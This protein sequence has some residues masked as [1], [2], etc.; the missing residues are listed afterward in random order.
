MKQAAIGWIK[1]RDG[2]IVVKDSSRLRDVVSGVFGEVLCVA[3]GF[4]AH[5]DNASAVIQVP[6][7]QSD[8]KTLGNRY[9]IERAE[10]E[11]INEATG[12]L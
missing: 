2:W 1:L 11:I 12:F 9:L 5:S 10:E 8:L 6:Q 3:C 4:I 7:C